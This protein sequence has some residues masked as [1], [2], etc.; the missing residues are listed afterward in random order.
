MTRRL[1]SVLISIFASA[2]LFAAESKTPINKAL[3]SKMATEYHLA[4]VAKESSLLNFSSLMKGPGTQSHGRRCDDEQSGPS[5]GCVDAVC[6]KLGTYGCD[7]QSEIG[8][9]AAICSNQYNESCLTAAC[10]RL[11]T[12]GCDSLDEIKAVA[13]VCE[14]VRSTGCVDQV[15]QRLGTYGCD[16]MTEISSAAQACSGI[17]DSGCISALCDRL[18]TYGCDSLSEIEAVAKSCKGQ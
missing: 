10:S 17:R 12:Y 16:S 7:S 18:G 14:N 15:C 8:A 2:Q 5:G 6:Q 13:G 4:S 11:G 9:V 1:L 3:L